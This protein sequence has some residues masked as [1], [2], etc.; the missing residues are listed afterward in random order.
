[1]RRQRIARLF[2]VFVVAA[3]SVAQ[4]ASPA[5]PE[6][7]PLPRRLN[8]PFTLTDDHRWNTLGVAT[9]TPAS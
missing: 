7:S 1:M 9:L 3:L 5:W 2:G 4:H 8:I 6:S